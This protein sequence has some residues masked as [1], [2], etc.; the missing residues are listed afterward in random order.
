MTSVFWVMPHYQP[1]N[2][3][4]LATIFIFYTSCVQSSISTA[5]FYHSHVWC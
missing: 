5:G 1:V 4:L 3:V 2:K